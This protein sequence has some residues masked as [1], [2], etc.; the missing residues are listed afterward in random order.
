MTAGAEAR[1]ALP[2]PEA[3]AAM[4]AFVDVL[5][6][7]DGL[8]PPASAVGAHGLL[9][10]RLREQHGPEALDRVVAA[11]A[12]VAGVRPFAEL[13][14]E[15]RLAAVTRFEREEGA[16]F[17]TLRTVLYY[18]YYQ[19]PLVVRAIRALGHDYNDAP[20]PR[21]YPM[22]P[23]DPTPGVNAPATPRGWYKRTEEV[24]RVDLSGIPRP[25]PAENA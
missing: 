5:I 21:G 17:D 9:A 19:S 3:A 13:T 24:A 22:D 2:I 6:P 4:R 23:F 15:D 14:P 25:A 16:L 8:F 18:S 11:L 1:G 10:E 7:G 12:E 20:Q